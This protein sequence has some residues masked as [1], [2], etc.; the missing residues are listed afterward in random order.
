[1]QGKS[2][3][4][5]I[6]RTF[7]RDLGGAQ[8]T[9][10]RPAATRAREAVAASQSHR[11]EA[12]PVTEKYTGRALVKPS[13]KV[14]DIETLYELPWKSLNKAETALLQ[15]LQWSQQTWD[16]KFE[17]SARWPMTMRTRYGALSSTQRESLRQL[18]LTGDD[19]DAFIDATYGPDDDGRGGNAASAPRL[20]ALKA[21]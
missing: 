2:D 11:A 21:R 3:G 14:R 18:G 15:N 4:W 12:P 6:Q 20:S 8:A 10:V 17:A 7:E 19:W 5:G 9:P 16:T 13:V 1:V